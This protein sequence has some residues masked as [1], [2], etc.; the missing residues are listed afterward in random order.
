TKWTSTGR[1]DRTPDVRYRRAW[2]MA[3]FQGRLFCGTLP[4][5]HVH[6]LDVGSAVSDDHELKPGWRHLAAVRQ[7]LRLK[8]FVD[9]KLVAA[10]PESDAGKGPAFD[11]SNDRPLTIGFGTH[12]YF[13]GS[14]SDLRLYDRALTADEIAALARLRQ[15]PRP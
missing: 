3:I 4:S 1:L 5:G 15:R 13:R 9:G 8:L 7:G 14:L 6:A 12:D 11:L 10:S 2:S